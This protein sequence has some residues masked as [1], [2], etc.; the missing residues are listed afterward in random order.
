MVY[1]KPQELINA[2]D[3]MNDG[4]LE[5]ALNKVSKFENNSEITLQDQLSA[6]LIKGK[7]FIFFERYKEVAEIGN[8]AYELSKKLERVSETIEALSLKAFAFSNSGQV[9]NALNLVLEAEELLNSVNIIS[10]TQFSRLKI[11]ILLPKAWAYYIRSDFEKGLEVALDGFSL[12]E[13]LGLKLVNLFFLLIT[14]YLYL[15]TKGDPNAALIY[16]EKGLTIAKELNSQ[17]CIAQCLALF[18]H[19]YYYKGDLSQALELCHKGLMIKEI[20]G[21]S[22]G[23][24]L[25][26]LADIY[27]EK[28]ELDTSLDYFK[29][30]IMLAEERNEFYTLG[31]L[32]SRIATTYRIKGDSLEALKYIKRCVLFLEK[33]D[34]FIAKQFALL[35]QFFINLDDNSFEKAQESLELLKNTADRTTSKVISQIY[36]LAKALFL[37]TKSRARYRAE[38]EDILKQIIDDDIAHT[39]VYI[40][41]LVALCDFM[42]K[43][44]YE[45]NELEILDELEPLVSRLL[46]IAEDQNSSLYIA[47]GKLLKA[48]LAL[49]QMDLD[50]AKL[51]LTQA[52]RIAEMHGLNLMAHK[53]SSEHDILL[54]RINDWENLKKKNA[55]MAERIELAS[56]EGVLDRL[57]GKRA[58]EAPEL[59]NEKPTLLL[60]IAEG[61]V[62][63]FSYPFTDEWKRD[64]ELFSSF[65]SAFTSFSSEFFTKGL[66]R[67]K[68]GDD[69]ILM[70]S[71]GH[72]SI[73]YLFK[74]QTYPATQRLSKFT[75]E[76][77]NA[78]PVW[79]TLENFY[80]ASQVLE[81]KDSPKLESLITEIFIDKPK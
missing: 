17:T 12:G 67:A 51:L 64:D 66:D 27:R 13:K 30:G 65:L 58:I 33:E 22:K 28:G 80:N 59:I 79:Q 77:Q 40:L 25:L 72:F 74:G 62:L 44:L 35:D 34:F 20:G 69:L 42:F 71:I 7:L 29:K 21:G 9:E 39:Q 45:Y 19:I 70:E 3:L 37:K 31:A 32:L 24:I 26:T 38:A 68:F 75:E 73:C 47:E 1:S 50:D 76:I 63:L 41:S 15:V 61:G 23:I 54:E 48:K 8:S 60:I 6:L 78:T 81:L 46:K 53:I 5:E 49:I 4:K 11:G 57:Q 55:P 52:Q 56:I 14:S 16:A 36:L 43:E 18:S 10:S 2:E